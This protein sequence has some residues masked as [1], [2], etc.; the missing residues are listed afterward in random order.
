MISLEGS[1]KTSNDLIPL[2]QSV[3][4]AV[5]NSSCLL[6]GFIIHPEDSFPSPNIFSTNQSATP[7]LSLWDFAA[8]S[9]SS[10]MNLSRLEHSAKGHYPG[11]HVCWAAVLS[12]STSCCEGRVNICTSFPQLFVVTFP[13]I[14]DLSLEAETERNIQSKERAACKNTVKWREE[15]GSPC[16]P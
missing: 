2:M 12:N 10:G 16:S 7:F 11:L 4:Q 5:N 3:N 9:H 6:L 1:W 14:W 13:S 8:G 15:C